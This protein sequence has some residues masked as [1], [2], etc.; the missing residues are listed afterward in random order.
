MSAVQVAGGPALPAMKYFMVLWGI[1][2]PFGGMTTMSLHRA[3]AFG[4]AG[5]QARVLTFDIKPSYA[6]TVERLRSQGK[7][8]RDTE[9]LNVFQHYRAADVMAASRHFGRFSAPCTSGLRVLAD[10]GK[11]AAGRANWRM[12]SLPGARPRG[13]GPAAYGADAGA[14]AGATSVGTRAASSSATMALPRRE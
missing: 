3:G 1:A 11:P 14:H 12:P 5:Q 7:L 8:S 6:S 9:V 2:E 4:E 13:A 10:R